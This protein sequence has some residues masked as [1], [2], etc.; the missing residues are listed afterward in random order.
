M[1]CGV[2]RV[3]VHG[4]IVVMEREGKRASAV[5]REKIYMS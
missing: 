2:W 5:W 4:A 1:F 3:H